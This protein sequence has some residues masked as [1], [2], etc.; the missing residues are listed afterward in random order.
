MEPELIRPSFLSKDL[1][2][3]TDPA[4]ISELFPHFPHK[5]HNHRQNLSPIGPEQKPNHF[6]Q[7]QKHHNN[8]NHL[9]GHDHQLNH[10]EVLHHPHNNHQDV[11]HHPQDNLH[12]V[13]HHLVE[14][15][16]AKQHPLVEH[17]VHN[18]HHDS[19][20][21]KNK[22]LNQD[23]VKHLPFANHHSEHKMIGP[24]LKPN[25][26]KE[27]EHPDPQ[28]KFKIFNQNHQIHPSSRIVEYP[29]HK[30]LSIAEHLGVLN[31]R[32]NPP[33]SFY[34]PASISILPKNPPVRIPKFHHEGHYDKLG[35]LSRV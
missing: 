20:L 26:W 30:E 12:V 5:H 7:S 28:K 4:I 31:P 17:V 9:V 32:P 10:Q 18:K 11:L 29:I 25:N 1:H 21:H 15:N 27:T 16:P 35:V 2:R 22:H 23:S 34:S 6:E 33:D 13:Q 19:K 3:K 24:Q 8:Q 14:L